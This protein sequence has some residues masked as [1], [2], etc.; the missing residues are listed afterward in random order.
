MEN[1]DGF[2]K[3]FM[4]VA[5]GKNTLVQLDDLEKLKP[6]RINEF[7]FVD[8]KNGKCV[9]VEFDDGNWT[10]LPQ[11]FNSI[12]TTDQHIQALTNK[13]FSLIFL[14][15]DEKRMNMALLDFQVIPTA[16]FRVT[17]IGEPQNIFHELFFG[18]NLEDAATQKPKQK[19]LKR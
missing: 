14:G 6:Y 4:E 19:K 12:I 18:E 7:R 15:R 17:D 11:R 10:F 13:C 8:T 5:S 3:N 2:F 16:T 9:G 1:F